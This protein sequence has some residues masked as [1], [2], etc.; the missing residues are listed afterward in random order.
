MSVI[1]NGTN[2]AQ[3]I[4][5]ESQLGDKRL[6]KRLQK[7]GSQLS[8]AIGVSLASSCNGDDAALEGAYRFIRNNK[9]K[10]NKIAEGGYKAT[11]KNCK[12]RNVLLA[13]EDT[14]N[15]SFGHKV[16][17][18]LG[19]L[20][21]PKDAYHRGFIIH[22][23]LMI[24]AE[25]EETIGLIDQKRWCRDSASRGQKDQR[26][27]RLYINKESYKW[28]EC[29][30]NISRRLG[31]LMGQVI[32]VCDRE[33]DIYEY[34][35]YKI[36]NNQKFIVRASQD[37]R[38]KSKNNLLFEQKTDAPLLGEYKIEIAQKGG[39]VART[40]TIELRAKQ[41]TLSPPQ[42]NKK[43]LIP[44]IVN[45]VFA[46]EKNPE[47]D[48][49]IPLEWILLTTEDIKDFA[50]ARAITR[51]YEMRW[52]IEEFHKAWKTGAGAER[53]RMQ[54]ADN[55]EKM[56]VILSFIAVRLLQL[57]ES[58]E[59]DNKTISATEAKTIPCMTVIS[60]DEYKVLWYSTEK[61]K[62]LPKKAPSLGWA[63][64]AIA[65]LGGWNDTKKTGKASWATIWKGWFKLQERLEG[66]Q[67][68]Q[69]IKQN[70]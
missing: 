2:W 60:K 7:V 14:T 17:E 39:R 25:T 26:R 63:Y 70:L 37:R 34:I 13:V 6:T 65:K 1:L 27:K 12:E 32:S 56:I 42:M 58:F 59:A 54:E 22:S 8:E 33:S 28:E 44:L 55:L 50:K 36:S 40:A 31:R 66:L 51:Y 5:A 24:D 10:A 19:D 57:K 46:S 4:F 16:K 21:G 35:Q 29:S 49:E 43:D 18:Q 61:K 62:V 67:I 11:V 38:I 30:N 69:K 15:M 52:R 3:D 45:V 20:G 48:V 23:S 9:V 64:K 68:F 53:Q 41:V 47:K